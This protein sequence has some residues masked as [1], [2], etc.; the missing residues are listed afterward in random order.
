MI[1]KR[2]PSGI[3]LLIGVLTTQITL[4]QKVTNKFEFQFENKTLR[5]LIESPSDVEAS[6]VII[7]IPGSGK[8]DFVKGN[9]YSELRDKF[10]QAG[11]TVCLWDKMGCGE[12]ESEGE[13]DNQQPVDNSAEEAIA[14]INEL[15]R[16]QI[17]GSDKIGLWGIS[18]AGY[19]C[20]LI[21]NQYPI[22]FWISVSGTSELD[23]YRYLLE[24]NWTLKGY[25]SIKT[26]LLLKEWDFCYKALTKGDVGFDKFIS[27]TENLFNDS[28]YNSLGGTLPSKSEYQEMIDYYKNSG[29]VFDS[30]SGLQ[31]MVENFP[32]I[33]KKVNCPVLAIFGKKDTQVN[34]RKTL[35]LYQTTMGQNDNS[36][37]T[38]KTLDNCNHNMQK[39]DT[40]ALGEDLKK[41]NWQACDDYYSIITNWLKRQKVIE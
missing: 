14:A 3:L 10:V 4:G 26:N 23:N 30:I 2:I 17:D 28:F 33:L 38:I 34:W 8:T 35:E 31:I 18:R 36:I 24:R 9:W 7:L 22:D 40:G 39:C 15:K 13:F 41:Y 32:E 19:I 16:L 1:K 11:L 21:I 37:L 20:P 5:G 12:S 6:A 29:F 25:D 27:K